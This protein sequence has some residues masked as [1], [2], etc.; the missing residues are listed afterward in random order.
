ML[1]LAKLALAFILIFIIKIRIGRY[2]QV[3]PLRSKGLLRSN[4]TAPAPS[5][6]DASPR[7]AAPT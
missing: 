2:A 7:R 5:E 4:A 6:Q 3:A 1:L